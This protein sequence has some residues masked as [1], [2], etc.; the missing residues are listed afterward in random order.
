MAKTEPKDVA[1]YIHPLNMNGL[2]GRMLR[3]PAPTGKKR[4]MLFIYGHHSSIERWWGVIQD[5]NQYGAITVPDLPGFGGMDS[6]YKIDQKPTIDAMADYLASF[7]KLRYKNKRLTIVGLSYG[8]VVA[9]RMLQRYP[10]LAKKVDLL[11]SVAGFSHRDDFTIS[12]PYYWFY[13]LGSAFFAHRIPAFF[14]KNLALNPLVLRTVYARTTNAQVKFKDKT[15]EEHKRTMDFEIYLWHCNELRT[16]MFTGNSF[17]KVDNCTRQVDLP[18]WH[19]AVK[20]DQYFDNNL[21]EQ[22]MRII[23]NDFHQAV[24]KMEGH[25]PAVIADAKQAA[26]LF[27]TKLRRHLAKQA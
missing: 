3:M 11:V 21:I 7:V 27:P 18:V 4:E 9:T 13:R 17:L 2:S 24:S 6:F 10:D 1:D 15:K 22:H 23:F 26:P 5:L 16:Y 25:A 8:F 12:K 19:V 14:F 20:A